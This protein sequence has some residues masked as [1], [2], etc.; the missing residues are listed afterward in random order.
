MPEPH[1]SIPGPERSGHEQREIR[2]PDGRLEH[3]DVRYEKTD[4]RFVWVLGVVLVAC[5]VL[6]VEYYVTLLYFR[7]REHAQDVY[8]QSPYPLAPRPSEALPPEPRL[9][10]VDR[11]S[12]VDEGNVLVRERAKEQFLRSYGPTAEKDFVHVPIEEAM[13]F[14]LSELKSREQPEATSGKDSG[15]VGAG[16]SNSGRMFR[17]AT[18]W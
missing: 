1:E 13:R 9:E 12:G 4:V 15:L 17:G 16:A 6:G 5:V 10:E 14:V 3:P 18:R 8:K 11:R 7:N 2:H